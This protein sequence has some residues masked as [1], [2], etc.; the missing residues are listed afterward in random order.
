MDFKNRVWD[1]GLKARDLELQLV[2]DS[3]ENEQVR[4]RGEEL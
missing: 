3:R 1:D 4:W 2:A